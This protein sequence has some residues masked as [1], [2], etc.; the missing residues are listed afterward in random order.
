MNLVTESPCYYSRTHV[1]N[2]E[3][4][5]LATVKGEEEG[6][7]KVRGRDARVLGC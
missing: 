1:F 5:G 2:H 6:K 3:L 4:F 7:G